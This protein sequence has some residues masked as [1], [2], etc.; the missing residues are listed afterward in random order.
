MRLV[1]G[2]TFATALAMLVPSLEA[3]GQANEASRAVAGG[4][5]KVAGWT[6]KV[7]ANE[8][9]AGMTTENLKFVSE[10]GASM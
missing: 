10:G 6:G 9:A 5:I 4:G 8:A 1:Y 3:Q 2:L 7:D